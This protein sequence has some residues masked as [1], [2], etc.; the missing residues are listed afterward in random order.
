MSDRSFY[1]IGAAF[2]IFGALLALIGNLLH[3][4][5]SEFG[6]PEAFLRMTAESGVWIGAH[7]GI[8]FGI[9]FALGGLVAL[10]RSM[11]QGPGGTLARFAMASALVGG[12]LGLVLLA[13]DGV[14]AKQLAV[15]WLTAPEAEKAVA[16]RIALGVEQVI[17]ALFSFFNVAFFGAM[18]ILYGLAVAKSQTYPAW[19]G[20]VAVVLGIASGLL[21]LRMAYRGLTPFTVNVL[22]PILSILETLWILAMGVHLGRRAAQ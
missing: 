4:R 16:L 17:F 19:L 7:V 18:V 13:L 20:W 12:T 11:Y 1:R 6:N 2:A 10:A 5:T 3:P 21:G 22:F 14:A 15:A 8:T 9:L